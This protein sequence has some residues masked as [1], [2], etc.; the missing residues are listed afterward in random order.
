MKRFL[1]LLA[2]L[3]MSAPLALAQRAAPSPA[4]TTALEHLTAQRAALGLSEADFADVA[5]TDE[6]VSRTS[7]TTHLYLRQTVHGVEVFNARASAH[8]T[9]SGRVAG[10]HVGFI[11]SAARSVTPAE[12]SLSPAA[13]VEAAAQHLGLALTGAASVIE[14]MDERHRLVLSDAGVS[15]EP[16]P[17]QLVY[18][19]TEDG[20]LRLAWD[21][22]IYQLDAQHWWNLLVDAE[23][24]SVL[25]TFDWV[26]H[27]EWERTEALQDFRPLAPTPLVGARSG[28]GASYNVWAV[29]VESPIH[30][31]R[32]LEVDPADPTASPLGWH[33]TGAQ[34]YTITRGNNVHAYEDRDANNA[35][36][37]SP[38]GGE[39]LVFDFE[40]DFSTQTPGQYEDIAITNLFYW[41][42]VFHD[43]LYA[44]GF[45]E[46]GGNF[47]ANNFD[48]GGF[49]NDYVQA[50]AQDGASAEDCPS[51]PE[52]GDGPCLN[53]A[54]F[55]TPGDGSR[56]RMQM[57]EWQGPPT[58]TVTSPDSIAG[59]Y[60]TAPST[61]GPE[62]SPDM[63]SIEVVPVISDDGG[64]DGD[65]G[66]G[67]ACQEIFNVDELEGK[68]ALIE[69]GDCQFDE[70]VFA[71]EQA[72][73]VAAIIHNNSRTGDGETGDPEDL[74][75]MGGDGTPVVTIPSA[76]VQQSTGFRLVR[77][78]PA[79]GFL[80]PTINR[81]SDLDNGIIVH[82]YGHGVSNRLTGGP[83][84]SGC[85]NT[86]TTPEQMGEG[87]SDWYGLMMTQRE[88][89]TPEMRRGIGTYVIF[90]D[91]DGDGIRPF[92][93]STNMDINPSTYGQIGN[94]AVYSIPHGVGS[95]WAAMLWE[96]NW[97]LVQ[98]E[99][100]DADLVNGT[101]GNNIALQLVTEGMKMQ[102]CSPGFVD[103]RDAILEADTV[104]YD[105]AYS[106]IIW[107]AFAKRGLGFSADQ[108]LSSSVTDGTQAF[109]MPPTVASEGSAVPG[110]Y[111]VSAAYPNPFTG[112]TRFS[113]EVAEAQEVSVVVFDV[114]GREVATLHEGLLA[115]NAVQSFE[116]DGSRLAS[117]VYLVRV[118]GERFAETRRITLMQ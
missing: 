106:D 89:D 38:D 15:L 76:F 48:N 24:G 70:K 28:G 3:A 71:A 80:V 41:N 33:D 100:F 8:V 32:T 91:P 9:T 81:D 83:S 85:L 42:N 34:Q 5:V 78:A 52:P 29:P 12:P 44:Y 36:G 96:M 13:A 51:T 58:F 22:A 11:P 40:I 113:V 98:A 111:A 27:D 47:Q 102:P 7:G 56:P 97:G 37:Y 105:G 61:F 68:I 46:A 84:A 69:R 57:F 45:D 114:M 87:W 10:V 88:D 92:P 79:E 4:L 112:R 90:E 19:A 94:Q 93:Y 64:Q 43:V 66:A 73:A 21:L 65:E 107:T 67:R 14:P 118:T 23:T 104:L 95:V 55:A 20:T 60:P 53:N 108:G 30:G 25:E 116:V 99:G 54:N 82:E 117:G 39:D 31:E 62:F 86:Q 103:G 74:I 26:V 115:A 49:G 16:I 18:F 50:E 17:A 35:P 2:L 75:T 6:Y 101:S 109:D 59:G 110:V 63:T 1:L 77:A 72:G